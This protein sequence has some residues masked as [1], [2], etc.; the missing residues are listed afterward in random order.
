MCGGRHL[1]GWTQARPAQRRRWTAPPP[2]VPSASV[3]IAPTGQSLAAKLRNQTPEQ[4]S[5]T[6][7]N[8]VVRGG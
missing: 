5:D 6:K 4:N 7:P 8:S 1:T 3:T 2:A